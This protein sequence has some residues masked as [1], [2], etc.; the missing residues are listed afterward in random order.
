MLDVGCWSTTDSLIDPSGLSRTLELLW[1][2]DH[3]EG[4]LSASP[5]ENG[6]AGT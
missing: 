2:F 1:N 5:G 6:R 4:Y 3:E